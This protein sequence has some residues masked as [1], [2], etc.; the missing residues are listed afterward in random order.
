M[1]QSNNNLLGLGVS[2]MAGLYTMKIAPHYYELKDVDAASTSKIKWG[3]DRQ[4]F[5]M[6]KSMCIDVFAID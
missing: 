2:D 5:G 6:K 1:K 3:L 4:L